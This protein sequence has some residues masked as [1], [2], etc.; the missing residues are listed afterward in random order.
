[1]KERNID[2]WKRKGEGAEGARLKA[3]GKRDNAQG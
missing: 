2:I 3:E 1:M